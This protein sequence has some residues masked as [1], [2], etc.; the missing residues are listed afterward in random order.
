MRDVTRNSLR[1]ASRMRFLLRAR[2]QAR[3]TLVFDSRQMPRCRKQTTTASNRRSERRHSTIGLTPW[4]LVVTV[5]A[6]S[7]VCW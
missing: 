2:G 4:R 7:S 1:P 5:D 6:I 3:L